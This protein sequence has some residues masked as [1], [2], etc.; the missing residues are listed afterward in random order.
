MK[1]I[2]GFFKS[3]QLKMIIIYILLI[4]I[5]IQV[6]GAYFAQQLEQELTD[7]FIESVNDRV[8]LLNYNLQQAF[9]VDRSE[10][11][12]PSLEVDVR[13]IINDYTSDDLSE[14][15]VINNNGRVLGTTNQM[16]LH[17]VGKRT[18][19]TR[20][21]QALTGNHDEDIRYN[22]E[23]GH[24]TLVLSTPIYESEGSD[25]VVGALSIEASLEGV[26]GQM[27][28]INRIFA[29]GTMLA[30]TVSALLGILVARTITKPITEM[31]K[32][33]K[34][35]GQGDYSQK[36][37]VYG[38]DEIGQL[39]ET[40]NELGD[41]IKA[42]QAS[43]EGE[44]RKLSLVLTNMT[45]GVVATEETGKIILMNLPAQNLLKATQEELEDNSLIQL[46]G[47][48]DQ[49][50]D[51][52]ELKDM[53]SVIIDL[54]DEAQLL[55]VRA[56]FSEVQD[57]N[58]EFSG[59]I[60]V[61]SDVT[62]QEKVERERREFVAN[63]SHEL[64]TPLT[65]MRS[66]L[67]ALTDGDTWKDENI[68]PKF[69]SVTQNE[70]ER[71]IRLVNDLLQLSKMDNKDYQLHKER[72]NY[73]DFIHHV[74]DRFE[75]NL[76]QEIDIKRNVPEEK[77]NVWVDKDKV[78]Q[79]LDNIIS[80]AIK[81]SPEGGEILVEVTKE[82]HQL[83]TKVTDEGVGIP[84]SNIDKIFDRFYRVDKARSRQLGGTG[85]GLAIAKELIE[86]HDGE[87]WAKSKENEGTT[88]T[89]RLP[90]MQK[91][92]GQRK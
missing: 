35:M 15:L 14:I 47:M 69:L 61:I 80:N 71:M 54:S 43:T 31:R 8:E 26:Y 39:A 73:T 6:I 65:T 52:N 76:K 74:V 13:E 46:L 23:N 50:S 27:N 16:E 36:V 86:A 2:W 33:A 90:L 58:E 84:E 19:E 75:L 89:F 56:N 1:T 29:N 22:E 55:L 81:Y 18:T 44:R 9:Q 17:N 85:L 91:K 51:I 68:A 5:T 21:Q 79:V 37:N 72:V 4:L 57:E 7:N 64:R 25:E 34:L 83:L 41:K 87:V 40:F 12:T 3:I 59:I 38:T 53:K 45:D 20:I 67:E 24:R 63:V 30:I 60:T 42:A 92:R 62:E 82:K 88:I 10:E 11:G 49:V 70:T 66:Y 77:Y 48:E 78:T 32:Q 28:D